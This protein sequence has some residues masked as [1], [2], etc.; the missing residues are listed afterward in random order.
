MQLAYHI[1][2]IDLMVADQ[3]KLNFSTEAKPTYP[4][5]VDQ[6]NVIFD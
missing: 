2:N 4:T 1:I 3:I 6:E 5:T